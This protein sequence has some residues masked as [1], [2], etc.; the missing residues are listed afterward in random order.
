MVEGFQV[1][2]QR[3]LRPNLQSLL[4]LVTSGK[5]DAVLATAASADYAAGLGE[6]LGFQH[7]LATPAHRNSD[8]TPNRGPHKRHRVLEFLEGR[9]WTSRPLILVTDHIDDLPLMRESQLVC[10][11]GSPKHIG[12]ARAAAGNAQFIYCR[13]LSDEGVLVTLLSS[14]AS[15]SR[16][17]VN[18]GIDA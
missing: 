4:D 12:A 18:R 14:S 7:V 17:S 3:Q 15:E 1:Y 16:P 11:F 5:V 6:R 10:W 8:D 2:L 9:N 13:D